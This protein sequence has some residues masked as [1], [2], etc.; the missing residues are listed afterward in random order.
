MA[1]TEAVNLHEGVEQK[2]LHGGLTM[3]RKNRTPE[4]KERRAKIR[5]LLQ[6]G[7]IQNKSNGFSLEAS[8][9]EIY[10]TGGNKV[11]AA[12]CF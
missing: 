9:P 4:E 3:S 11:A 10:L 1:A 7:G 12:E 6:M 8:G 2:H 5:E